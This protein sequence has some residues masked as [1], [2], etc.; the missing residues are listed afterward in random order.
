MRFLAPL[1]PDAV[2]KLSALVVHLNKKLRNCYCAVW[3]QGT[4]QVCLPVDVNVLI[5][6]TDLCVCVL[7]IVSGSNEDFIYLILFILQDDLT[8]WFI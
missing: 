8:I 5:L 6:T 3:L 1:V 4:F 7:N 2:S